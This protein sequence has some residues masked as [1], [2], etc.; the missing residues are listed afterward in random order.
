VAFEFAKVV[1]VGAG[2]IGGSFSLALKAA[3]ATG[4][5]V[6][7]GRRPET[8]QRALSLGIVD[9]VGGLDAATLS[10]A[11]LVLIA[12]PVAQTGS[13]L[14]SVAPLLGA[15]TIVTDAGSTKQD[16]VAAARAA[17]GARIGRFVPGHPIAGTE[18]SGPEAAFSGLFRDRNVVL[19]P[20]A[21]NAAADVVRVRH[22]WEACGA[23]VQE[24]GIAEHD[25][26]LAAVSHLPH[27]LAFALVDHV[28][29]RPGGDKFMSF[30][31]GGFRDFTRIASSHPEMWRDICVAN[32]TALLKEL[33][34]Y[35]NVLDA[36]RGMVE[37]GDAAA[38]Y[39]LFEKAREARNRWLKESG[40]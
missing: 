9:A 23:R 33:D 19:T 15:S 26:I 25:E 7:V 13:V 36:L 30:A 1:V 37:R 35:G 20:L 10:D 14:A 3:G 29:G 17:M 12:V 6:G 38:L 24:L 40:S 22:A 28:A 27:A 21:E 2:L 4:R 8:L 18:H 34:G 16:V 5:I 32:R 31:A 39:A 11:E